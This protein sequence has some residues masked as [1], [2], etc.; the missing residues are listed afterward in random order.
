MSAKILVVDDEPDLEL[1]ITQKFRKEVRNKELIFEFAANGVEALEKLSRIPDVDIVLTDLNMPEMDGLTLLREL[2]FNKPNLKAIVLSAYG[3][4]GN[5]RA[6]MNCG[7]FDFL[8]KPIDFNDLKITLAKTL[9]SVEELREMDRVRREKDEALKKALEEERKAKE[10]QR[11]LIEHL[12]KMDR[13]KDEFLA[14]TSHELKTP[15]NGIIGIVDSL[16]DGVAG[17]L[18]PL[19]QNNLEMVVSSGR[20]LSRLVDDILDF[21]KMKSGQV[22]LQKRPINIHHAVEMVLTLSQP[23][24]ANRNVELV[25]QLTTQTPHVF[26]DPNRLQQILFNLVGNAIKFTDSGSVCA[27]ARQEGDLCRIIISD[28]GI[29][30]PEERFK[31]I[32]QMFEQVEESGT[33]RQGGAGLGLAITR[34]LVELNGGKIEVSSILGEGSQ[35]SFTLPISSKKDEGGERVPERLSPVS[36]PLTPAKVMITEMGRAEDRRVLVVDDEPINQQVLSNHLTLQSFHVTRAIDGPSALKLIAKKVFDLVILDVMM[37]GMSG[38]EVCEA[39]RQ[40]YSLHE[41]PVLMLT[42]KNQ[43]ADLTKGLESGANDY[44]TKPFDKR[45]MLARVTSLITLRDTFT[46]AMAHERRLRNEQNRSANLANEAHVLREKTEILARSEA[47][48]VKD[49]R[50]KTDFLAIMSHELRTPLNAIIGYS[51]ILHEDLDLEGQGGFIPD[52]VKIQTAARNLLTLINNLLDLTK[53]EAGKMDLFTEDLFLETLIEEVTDTLIPLITQ[54]GNIIKIHKSED[55]P[56]MH[57][58]VTKLRMILMNLLSNACKFTRQGSIQFFADLDGDKIRIKITDTGVGMTK[59]QLDRVFKPFEQAEMST[60]SKYGGTGLG[61]VITKRF[62][63]MLG[64]EI[65]AESAIGEGATFVLHFPVIITRASSP[66][67]LSDR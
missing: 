63:N 13:L 3:D 66:G 40:K 16:L 26:A 38:Y 55:L 14:S 48:A 49:S 32:F 28:T 56:M 46:A 59:E 44:L 62:C 30:I 21:S 35:F 6:A 58:D 31:D 34:K 1:L 23:L 10:S 43:M 29:G 12:K 27:S 7:A 20:R 25:N 5:I 47:E 22:V 2:K 41:L 4:L 8:T 42:A 18:N 19:V 52:I 51:E 53:M 50:F 39:I 11:K 57:T 64:G 61:L 24:V 37:P 45:E 17:A 9:K 33:R 65:H 54:N 67:L 15:I 36:R 60:T